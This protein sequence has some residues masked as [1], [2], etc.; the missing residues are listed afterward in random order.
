MTDEADEP[1][2]LVLIRE[3]APLKRWTPFREEVA[4]DR[5]VIHRARRIS[6]KTLCELTMTDDFAPIDEAAAAGLH[7][8]ERRGC[9]D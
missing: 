7:T 6:P 3:T 9:W 8:C 1:G 2:D 4:S 5:I